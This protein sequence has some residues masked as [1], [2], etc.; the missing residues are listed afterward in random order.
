MWGSE[1]ER[2]H[3]NPSSIPQRILGQSI[4]MRLQLM[5]LHVQFRLED[6]ELLVQ[7]LLIGAEEVVFAEMLLKRIVVNEI[8]LIAALPT[9]ITNMASFVLVSAMSIELVI[10]I[11]SRPTET[12]FRMTLEAALIYRTRIVVSKTLMF[13]Q[14]LRCEQLMLMREDLLVPRAEVTHDF[15]MDIFDMVMEMWPAQAGLVTISIGAVVSKKDDG[16]GVYSIIRILDTQRI[17]C[18]CDLGLLKLFK[19]PGLIVGKDEVFCFRLSGQQ[20]RDDGSCSLLDNGHRHASCIVFEAAM[21]RYGMCGDCMV[22][23]SDAG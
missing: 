8:L 13:P 20:R 23:W 21:H 18:M 17:V 1:I 22:L 3:V 10:A 12:T 6:H 11:K 14:L 16:V 15:V 4:G 5:C 9:S 19:S 2:G 7:T